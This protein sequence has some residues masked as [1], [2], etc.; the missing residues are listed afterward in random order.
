MVAIEN[1]RII[2][3]TTPGLHTQTDGNDHRHPEAQI[4]V[5]IGAVPWWSTV[6]SVSDALGVWERHVVPVG[7]ELGTAA[8]RETKRA[9]RIANVGRR[10][11]PLRV[12]TVERLETLFPRLDLTKVRVRTRCRLPPNRF[13][14]SGSIY[15]MTF[16][17]TI[18]WRD[19]LDEDDPRDLV[20]L[21]HELV[22]VDQVRRHGGETRFACAYGTGYLDGGGHLPG[23]IEEPSRY[24]LNPLEAEA[25]SF[26]SRFRDRHG[27]VVPE[28]LP[29]ATGST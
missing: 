24:H 25:Y 27:R 9:A 7:C 23:Y 26:E 29:A 4:H 28:S 22:H 8:F 15:A 21:I 14:Q 18:Y 12:D 3:S 11:R 17:N 6:R 1:G 10:A 13:R 16:G 19:E 20:K 2:V 5:R